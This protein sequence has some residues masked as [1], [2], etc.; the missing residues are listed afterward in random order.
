M[1]GYK[2]ADRTP[3]LMAENP[4]LT[5]FLAKCQ[6]QF[7][8][9]NQKTFLS[10]F[11]AIGKGENVLRGFAILYAQ[12]ISIEKSIEEEGPHLKTGIETFLLIHF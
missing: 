3:P 4:P 2:G 6:I 5:F 1:F 10:P 12:T 7:R 8:A 9:H 11:K